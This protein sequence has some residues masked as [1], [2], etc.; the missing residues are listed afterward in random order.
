MMGST[1]TICLR[2]RTGIDVDAP[3]STPGKLRKRPLDVG[4]SNRDLP[5]V[6]PAQAVQKRRCRTEDVESGSEIECIRQAFGLPADLDL[7]R[8][9]LAVGEGAHAEARVRR[10]SQ[11]LA[12]PDLVARKPEVIVRG[13]VANR[14]VARAV[15][16]Q[17]H[18]CRLVATT[19]ATRNLGEQ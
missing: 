2:S 18:L 5:A 9:V 12:H 13:G 8:G 11:R 1:A 19:R 7:S 16:L 10:E 14:V 3:A 6:F 15:G 4:A 17:H